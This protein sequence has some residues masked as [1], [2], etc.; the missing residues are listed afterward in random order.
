M[1]YIYIYY[2]YY[3]Y[4][5]CYY[6]YCYCYYYLLLFIIIVIVIIYYYLLLLITIITIK[7]YIISNH[8]QAMAVAYRRRSFSVATEALAWGRSH[9]SQYLGQA[10]ALGEPYHPC[11]LWL[12]PQAVFN[13][14]VQRC[15]MADSWDMMT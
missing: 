9:Q 15:S 3:Y 11:R 1:L 4:Y 5:Y 8:Y 2:Y 14:C 7:L 6:C 10:L 13:G 12:G